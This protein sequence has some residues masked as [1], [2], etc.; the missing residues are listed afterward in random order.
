LTDVAKALLLDKLET[1]DCVRNV[2]LLAK[3]VCKDGVSR[4]LVNFY[5]NLF[6]FIVLNVNAAAASCSPCYKPHQNGADYD[7]FAM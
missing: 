7:P 5:L 4:L 3:F 1:V 6:S 2:M